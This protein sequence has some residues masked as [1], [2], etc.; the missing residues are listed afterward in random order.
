MDMRILI[1]HRAH[2]LQIQVLILGSSDHKD[3]RA[4]RRQ[5]GEV[6]VVERASARGFVGCPERYAR[7]SMIIVNPPPPCS[8]RLS[9]VV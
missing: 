6:K 9:L 2:V 3:R 1:G 4:S 5:P 8:S 7:T